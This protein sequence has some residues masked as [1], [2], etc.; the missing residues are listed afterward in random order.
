MQGFLRTYSDTNLQQTVDVAVVIPTVLRPQLIRALESIYAQ[1]FQGRIQILVGVDHPRG[2]LA[3]IDAACAKPPSHCSVMVFWPGY[4][5]SRRHGG[6]TPAADGGALRTVLTYLANSPYIAYLDDDYWWGANHL[7]YTRSALGDADW[8]FALRWFVHPETRRPVCVDAW[9]S[10]GPGKGVYADKFGGFVDPNCLMINR[11]AC[12][13]AGL[14]WNFP[15]TPA[16]MSADRRVFAY[17]AQ[18]HKGRGTGQPTVFYMLQPNDGM[19]PRRL[20]LMG[21]AYADAGRKA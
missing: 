13:S 14:N 17:L 20:Q 21:Q 4:S 16:A 15:L 3:V 8:A 7:T 5:T 2:D 12:P 18:N 9:E 6:L 10:V 19:H 11:L 1:K